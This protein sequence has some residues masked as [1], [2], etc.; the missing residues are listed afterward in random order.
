MQYN[1]NGSAGSTYLE[2]KNATS[3]SIQALKKMEESRKRKV[4]RNAIAKATKPK[5]P[6]FSE[7]VREK[8]VHYGK[9]CQRIDMSSHLF[10]IAKTRYLESLI[11]DQR[12]RDFIM[13][14]T[15]GQKKTRLWRDM[16]SKILTSYYF[17][18]IVKSRSP[19]SYTK[20]LDDIVYKQIVLNSNTGEISHQHIYEKEALR[21][22]ILVHGNNY[23]SEC[24]IFIDEEH[25]FLGASPF[26]LYGENG[27]LYV[28]CPLKAF[29]KTI[30]EAI[31]T[32][33][34]NFW[35]VK[36]GVETVNKNSEWYIEIQGELH[37]TRRSFAFVIVWVESEFKIE[38]IYRDDT[39]WAEEMEKKIVDFYENVMVKEQVDPRKQRNMKLRVYNTQTKTF[40]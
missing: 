15:I 5:K 10:D 11:D 30:H 31:A 25:C 36:S 17:S 40:E 16:Q 32:K 7:Q 1:S 23:L 18:R 19:S 27:I 13:K 6:R 2:S 21:C 20:L 24:G 8:G 12:N 28:K 34:L 39:F 22:F 38:R 26:R 3:T 9:D 33:S 35:V 37:V 29:K 4:E 14:S